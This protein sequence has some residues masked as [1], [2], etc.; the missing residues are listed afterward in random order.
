MR[1]FIVLPY[2]GLS[3]NEIV[4]PSLWRFLCDL[5]PSCG[6]KV[7]LDL[8]SAAP[9]STIHPVFSLLILFCETASTYIW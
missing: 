1:K 2:T 7:F 6:L 3:Y 4:L 8:L 5:G 9:G